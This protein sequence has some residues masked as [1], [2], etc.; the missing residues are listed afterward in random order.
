MSKRS[1]N[2]QRTAPTDAGAVTRAIAALKRRS[3]GVAGSN[4]I[5]H[6]PRDWAIADGSRTICG[7]IAAKVNC[8]ASPRD[9]AD[10]DVCH[11]CKRNVRPENLVR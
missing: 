4:Y 7:R 1:I 5:R 2:W 9:S 11:A 6:I 8:I 10:S 3:N